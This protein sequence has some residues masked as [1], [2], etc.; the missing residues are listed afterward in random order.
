MRPGYL[1]WEAWEQGH[2]HGNMLFLLPVKFVLDSLSHHI[3]GLDNHVEHGN[4]KIMQIGHVVA[5]SPFFVLCM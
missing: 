2:G 3:Q 5:L 1:T 4:L